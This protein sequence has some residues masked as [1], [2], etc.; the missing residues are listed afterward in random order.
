ME[1]SSFSETS[2]RS[3]CEEVPRLYATQAFV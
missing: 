3:A 2:T 1:Q